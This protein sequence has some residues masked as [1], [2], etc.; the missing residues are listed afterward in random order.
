VISLRGECA[1]H[2]RVLL[3]TVLAGPGHPGAATGEGPEGAEVPAALA[4]L[5]RCDRCRAE[6]E[7]TSL[8]VFTLRRLGD[9]AARVEP[10]ATAW[11]R[12]RTALAGLR[13]APS[14]RPVFMSPIAG[15][16]L[17]LAML[18]AVNVGVAVRTLP[19]ATPSPVVA[20]GGNP[21]DAAELGWLHTHMQP[22]NL[23]AAT[24]P[25]DDSDRLSPGSAWPGPD[26]RAALA[27][28]HVPADSA[29]GGSQAPAADPG[30]RS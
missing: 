4:H 28:V 12:L 16:A 17:S 21:L 13:P 8:L 26:G 10:P 19:D 11:H 20:P 6:L 9:E 29:A 18:V 14:A 7:A 30:R 23:S 22:D 25:E 3:D 1:R 2:R 27:D 15:M 24:G 5:D